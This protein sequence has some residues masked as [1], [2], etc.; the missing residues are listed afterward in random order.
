HLHRRWGRQF[1]HLA[2]TSEAGVAQSIPTIR[3]LLKTV[4]D[5]ASRYLFSTSGTIL[6]FGSFATGFVVS[7]ISLILLC[8]SGSVGL[9]GGWRV[10]TQMLKF[11][12]KFGYQR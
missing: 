7:F 10:G 1:Y 11:C 9:D 5:C 3:A 12:L 8:G 2:S 4:L 6:L